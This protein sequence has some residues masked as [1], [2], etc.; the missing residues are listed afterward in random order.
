MENKCILILLDG[1]NQEIGFEQLGFLNHLVEHGKATRLKGRAETPSNSRPNYEVIHT[2]VPTF[3]NGITNNHCVQTSKE[4]HL[5]SKLK[6]K[7]RSTG[8]A[9]Y[10]WI[11]ELYNHAPFDPL[12]DRIQLNTSKA[13]ENGIF[14][15]EDHYPDTHLFADGHYIIKRKN[16]DYML[17]HSMNVDYAG[18]HYGSQSKEYRVAVNQVD[19]IMASF[20]PQWL[21]MGYQIIVMSDH[22]MDEWGLHGGTLDTHRDIPLFIL[23]PQIKS[24]FLDRKVSQLEILSILEFLLGLRSDIPFGKELIND[25]MD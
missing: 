15:S 18:H 17:I 8:A 7:G 9:A 13:I 22:G 19:T 6:Q 16:P 24:G 25:S 4:A 10:Y 14:Y 5:F 23:S 2:G 3:E 12:N 20:I 21:E 1:L 11:S